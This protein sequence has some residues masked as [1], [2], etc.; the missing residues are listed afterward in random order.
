MLQNLSAYYLKM[1]RSQ[2]T[3][4]IIAFNEGVSLDYSAIAL[5]LDV[6]FKLASTDLEHDPQS[7]VKQTQDHHC[8]QSPDRSRRQEYFGIENN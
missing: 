5:N 4:R 7:L 2:E 8:P 1:E 3:F 6:P